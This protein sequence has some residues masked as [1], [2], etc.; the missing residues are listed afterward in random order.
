MDKT[1]QGHGG[2]LRQLA[3]PGILRNAAKVSL[4]VGTVLNLVNQ[5]PQLLA[6][7]GVQASRALLNFLVPFCVA[8]YSG[9]RAMASKRAPGRPQRPIIWA[10]A[11]VLPW[12]AWAAPRAQGR[13]RAPRAWPIDILRETFHAT[14]DTPSEVPLERLV[15]GCPRRDCIP[16]I[17][18][19]RF[20]TAAQATFLKDTDLVLA[21]SV[22]GIHR[23]YPTSILVRHEIVNDTLGTQPVAITY[24]PLCGSGMAYSRVVGGRETTFG[25]SGLLYDSDLVMYD[26]STETLWPQILGRGIL[27]RRKGQVLTAL[28]LAHVAWKAWREQ[29]PDTQVLSTDT[30]FP[31]TYGGDPYGNYDTQPGTM[32]PIAHEDRRLHAKTV[33]FG[34][35]LK[36]QAAAWTE[37]YLK[38]NPV[39]EVD[40]AGRRLS[41][42]RQK[43]GQVIARDLTGDE[44]VLVHRLFW[45]AWASTYPGTRLNN[46]SATGK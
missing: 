40:L 11:L 41:V 22:E 8:A 9:A 3:A 18:R 27:G 28:P 19:P 1:G 12:V 23:A 37:T 2:W 32:F 5:G 21:L 45:F 25:V 44:A 43:N 15:Q 10:L 6:G 46:L 34:V 13:A 4:M 26:R 30:G 20:V 29:H 7:Q 35:N 24:C 33:V 38:A 16:S 31:F 14:A 39:L 17:D 36:G 42:R